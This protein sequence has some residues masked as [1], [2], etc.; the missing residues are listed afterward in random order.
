VHFENVSGLQRL[1][2]KFQ[3]TV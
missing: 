3:K 1:Q 2:M